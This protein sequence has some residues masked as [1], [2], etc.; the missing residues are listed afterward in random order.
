MNDET[1]WYQLHLEVDAER[2]EAVCELLEDASP[3]AVSMTDLADD[4]VYEPAPGET[5]LW[6]DT[7]VSALFPAE[8]AGELPGLA[9]DIASR[10]PTGTPPRW[11]LERLE[12]QVWERVWLDDFRP[13][14]CGHGLWVCPSHLPPPD[15]GAVNIRLDP[16][17]AFGSG[18]HP[19][20]R[21][22]LEWLAGNA[23]DGQTIIDY[24]CGSG[25]LGIAA[26]RLGAREVHAVDLD[27]Q[28]LTATRD[29]AEANGVADR[30]HT[31]LPG[32]PLA[33]EADGLLANILAGPLVELM[34]LFR[35]HVRR[36]GWIVL[37]GILNE[38]ARAVEAAL[39]DGFE[40]I[41]RCA[42]NGWVRIA[43]R[44][45]GP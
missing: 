8:R 36:G 5:L 29:N 42:R 33:T 45:S 31:R 6:P 19:T 20:T 39:A 9:E 44:R 17:L 28:A 30:I 34:P 26:L 16:G 35:M 37:S 24:G 2:V 40:T 22:C 1:V 10:L 14:D 4:P 7:R 3:L 12:D 13:I 15:P 43:A 21:L 32:E 41:D 27:P 38:Q 25:I 11:R 18:T 23:V